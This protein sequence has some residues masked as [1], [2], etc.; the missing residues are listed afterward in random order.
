MPYAVAQA[1]FR[2]NCWDRF[3]WAKFCSAKGAKWSTRAF[4]AETRLSL[5]MCFFF[6]L[7]WSYRL[8]GSG[9]LLSKPEILSLVALYVWR[10]FMR[11]HTR[12]D[13]PVLV[14]ACL[15]WD[16]Y[17]Q[18]II[19]YPWFQELFVPTPGQPG[20]YHVQDLKAQQV[21]RKAD[22]AAHAVVHHKCSS[23]VQYTLTQVGGV[24]LC[25]EDSLWILVLPFDL[26]RRLWSLWTLQYILHDVTSINEGGILEWSYVR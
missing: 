3:L 10:K 23:S 1:T 22:E 11:F 15:P 14:N 7:W 21:D 16:N 24:M 19:G 8:A 9:W 17:S 12:W 25:A 26:K 6:S 20:A 13:C 4:L 2:V 5:D 18:V